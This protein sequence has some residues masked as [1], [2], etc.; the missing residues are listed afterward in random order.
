MQSC[1]HRICLL[2]HAAL[3]AAAGLAPPSNGSWA[4]SWLATGFCDM[5]RCTGQVWQQLLVCAAK[6]TAFQYSGVLPGW[7]LLTCVSAKD[8]CCCSWPLLRQWHPLQ[9]PR[10]TALSALA[11][12]G[13]SIQLLTNRRQARSHPH[14]CRRA[15]QRQHSLCPSTAQPMPTAAAPTPTWPLHHT[16]QVC[17]IMSQFWMASDPVPYCMLLPTRAPLDASVC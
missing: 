14:L 3:A 10:P 13:S 1:L 5:H 11:C 2:Q 17:T 15:M 7:K 12:A 16:L 6:G 8:P 4:G 9:P